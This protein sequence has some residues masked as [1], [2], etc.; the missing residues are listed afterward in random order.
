MKYFMV[1]HKGANGNGHIICADCAAMC[2]LNVVPYD[3]PP[4]YCWGCGISHEQAEESER[5]TALLVERGGSRSSM[6][7]AT[8]S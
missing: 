5:L 1:Q 7:R 8:P 4:L 2:D 6:S 3:A